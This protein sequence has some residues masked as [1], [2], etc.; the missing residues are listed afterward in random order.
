MKRDSNKKSAAAK[1]YFETKT[2]LAALGS[3]L[4]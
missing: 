1:K 2:A 4:N 3:R